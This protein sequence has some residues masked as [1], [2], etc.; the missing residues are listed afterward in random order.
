M[1]PQLSKTTW[2]CCCLGCSA[3]DGCWT[4]SQRCRSFP[5]HTLSAVR[6]EGDI[7]LNINLNFIRRE[8]AYSCSFE[9]KKCLFFFLTS[10]SFSS[11]DLSRCWGI[12]SLK[13]FCRARNWAS[14]PCRK[15]QFTYNLQ[16]TWRWKEEE[17]TQREYSSS[18]QW[19]NDKATVWIDTE[20]LY[21]NSEKCVINVGWKWVW[22]YS[23]CF[24]IPDILLL[25]VLWDGDTL[26]VG[27]QFMLDDF[28]VGIVL[29]TESVVQHP[30][31]VIVPEEG[32][33]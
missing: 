18:W 6:S 23:L 14:M 3:S 2:R 29:H 8:A 11:K 1:I 17:E 9:K 32:G 19:M 20:N 21:K 7:H 5:G 12:T 33:G 22:S 24:S 13:P 31:D 10:S 28:S 4:S 30:S 27:F 15:R 26:A 25:G 16:R